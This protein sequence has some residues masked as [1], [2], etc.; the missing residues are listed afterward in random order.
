MVILYHFVEIPRT[1]SEFENSFIF[2][3]FIFQFLN[4]YTTIF[5]I[6]FFKGK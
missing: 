5:Y 6:A 1:V 2:K 4:Y 3:M